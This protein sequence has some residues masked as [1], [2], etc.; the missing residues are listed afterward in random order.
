MDPLIPFDVARLWDR[1]DRYGLIVSRQRTIKL[2][3]VLL[4]YPFLYFLTVQNL[5]SPFLVGVCDGRTDC[6]YVPLRLMHITIAG[7]P[8]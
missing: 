3:S 8:C 4:P 1:M 6:P 7:S 5:A 2:A